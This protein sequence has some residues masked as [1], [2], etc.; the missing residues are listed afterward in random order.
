MSKTKE[1]IKKDM[2]IAE[3]AF[4]YHVQGYSIMPCKR[5]KRPAL[6]AWKKYQSTKPTD[7]E[8]LKWFSSPNTNIGIITGKISGLTVID[9]DNKSTSSEVDGQQRADDMLSKFPATYTIKTPS[10]GYHLYYQYADGFT[11]SANAYPQFPS[12][13]IRGEGGF[14]VA[15]PS[16]TDKGIYA[17]LNDLPI[18]PFPA[19]LFPKIKQKKS[20]TEKLTAKNGNRNESLTSFVGQLLQATTNEDLWL[21]EVLPAVQRANKTYTPSLPDQ[22]VLTVFNSIAKKERTRRQNLALSPIGQVPNITTS[23]GG[24]PHQNMSNVV[25]ILEAHADFRNKI[26]Y[27]TFRQEIEIDGTPVEDNDILKVQY[28]LQTKFGL[29]TI[30]KEAVF[31]A[32]MHCAYDNAYDEAQDWL[33]SLVWDGTP[34]LATWLT[35]SLGVPDDTYHRGIGSQWFMGMIKRIMLPGCLFDNLLVL[36]A[37]QG[38]G[39]TSFFRIIGGKWYK[40]YTGSVESK[41]FYLALRGALLIDLDEGSTLYRSDAIKIKSIITATH[42]EFRAPY[43]RLMKKFPRRFVFSMSTNDPEPFQDVTGNR[44]YWTIDFTDTV[45]FKWLEENRDQIF[46]EAYHYFKNKIDISEVPMDEAEK[47]QEEHLHDDSWTDL[48]V[49][50]VMKSADYCE[51]DPLFSLTVSEIY[52]KIF[53]DEKGLIRLDKRHEMRIGNIFRKQLGLEKKR[54]MIDGISKNRYYINDKKLKELQERKLIPKKDFLDTEFPDDPQEE[55]PFG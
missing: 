28:V 15:P 35:S 12:M 19:D 47:K 11:V 4:A 6:L 21:T 32:L 14:V 53:P 45:D 31:S 5:D 34:R 36:V 40:S 44:R 49:E 26:R 7:D 27:N 25:A 8:I 39:K 1:N 22:E 20:L 37:P 9:I 18:A 42:D 33:T 16:V 13:D 17:P 38:V 23:K 52:T 10:G 46:A 24:T 48:V 55:I 50:E 51:G 54:K 2:T 41:D 3:Q 43:D 30:N 29:H